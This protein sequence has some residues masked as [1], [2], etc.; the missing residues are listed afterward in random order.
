MRQVALCFLRWLTPAPVSPRRAGCIASGPVDAAGI[1][2]TLGIMDVDITDVRVQKHP[3][4]DLL[5]FR[6]FNH[7]SIQHHADLI[8][9][10]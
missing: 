7:I 1:A 9:A 5:D 8:E 10:T 2:A 3:L 6:T 4:Y